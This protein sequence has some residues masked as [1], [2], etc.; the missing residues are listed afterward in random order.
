MR[1]EPPKGEGMSRGHHLTALAAV[2]GALA[3]AAPAAQ[4]DTGAVSAP[5]SVSASQQ[6]V[7]NPFLDGAAAIRAGW[8]AGAAAGIAGWQ[9]GTAAGIAGMQAGM[10]GAL[11]GWQAGAA[12][13]Q[14]VFQHPAAALPGG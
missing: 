6:G 12:A 1:P 10:A 7:Q 9:A 4:A 5:Q 3:I 2:I 14:G 8:A 13:M 11:Y